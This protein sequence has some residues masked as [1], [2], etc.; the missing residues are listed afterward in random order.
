MILN[1]LQGK[2]NLLKSDHFW[3][4]CKTLGTKGNLVREHW[5]QKDN[6]RDRKKARIQIHAFL[7]KSYKTMGIHSFRVPKTLE[8][9]ERER[10]PG[11]SKNA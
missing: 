4:S 2:E 7:L 6:R 5:K 8:T 9:N 10:E 3:K 11:N 1:G